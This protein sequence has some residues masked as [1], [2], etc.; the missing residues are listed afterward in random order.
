MSRWIEY[1]FDIAFSNNIKGYNNINLYSKQNISE[2]QLKEIVLE[3]F[4]RNK[5]ELIKLDPEVGFY[6][7]SKRLN[8]IISDESTFLSDRLDTGYRRLSL[9]EVPQMNEQEA[10]AIFAE[11]VLKG[12]AKG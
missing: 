5:E 6:I 12:S 8:K 10:K 9:L 3:T 7:D 4:N 2:E 1:D 11:W